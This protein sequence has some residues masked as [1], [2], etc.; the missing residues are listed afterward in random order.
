MIGLS[1]VLSFCGLG[2]LCLAMPRHHEQVFGRKP[3]RSSA[4][5]LRLSGWIV[6]GSALVPATLALG[7]S[8]GL[9]LWV[10]LLSV[11]AL[12]VG[13]LLSYQPRALSPALGTAALVVALC[14]LWVLLRGSA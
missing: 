13:L 4:L 2:L 12:G 1:L 8:V 5:A 3:D 6:L 14:L 10:S 7:V 9:A 11:A